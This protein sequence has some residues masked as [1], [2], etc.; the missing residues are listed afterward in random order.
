MRYQKGSATSPGL[1]CFCT[2]HN[3]DRRRDVLRF[4]ADMTDAAAVAESSRTAS[5][6]RDTA[7]L[8]QSRAAFHA[9]CAKR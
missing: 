5:K 9:Q 3:V 8:R 4:F 1:F 6:Y 7:H 2:E